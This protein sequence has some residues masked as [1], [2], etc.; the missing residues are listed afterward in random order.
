M[1]HPN[2]S[3][4]RVSG[5]VIHE[6]CLWHWQSLLWLHGYWLGYG[7]L[8]VVRFSHLIL[9]MSSGY[10]AEPLVHQQNSIL[11]FDIWCYFRVFGATLAYLVLLYDIWY[12]LLFFHNPLVSELLQMGPNCRKW[13]QIPQVYTSIQVS[14]SKHKW[15]KRETK[16]KNL[17]IK[18]Q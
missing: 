9:I 14:I 6:S 3:N 15:K 12:N 17:K 1:I 10:L 18:N 7:P 5:I 2:Y 13:V 8:L 11:L 16:K 4:G